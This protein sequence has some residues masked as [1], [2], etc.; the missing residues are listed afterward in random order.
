VIYQRSFFGLK[1][2]ME[3]QEFVAAKKSYQQQK[4]VL[5]PLK[6]RQWKID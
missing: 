2:I 4:S 6:L 1:K 3:I 5:Q